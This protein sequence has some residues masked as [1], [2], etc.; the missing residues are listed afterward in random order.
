MFTL[1]GKIFKFFFG[2]ALFFVLAIVLAVFA[3]RGCANQVN[4]YVQ[5]NREYYREA[6]NIVWVH[7]QA[8]DAPVGQIVTC[9]ICM[10]NAEST[11]NAGYRKN[12][13]GHNCC[14]PEHELEYQE[15]L[16]ALG[17]GKFVDVETLRRYGVYSK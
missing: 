13:P 3:V 15:I 9:A 6:Y 2:L 12:Y 16:R 14:K 17:D 7:E 11:L 5:E 1:I 10:K 4:N 8:E